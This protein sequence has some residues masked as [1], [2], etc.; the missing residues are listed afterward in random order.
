MTPEQLAQERKELISAMDAICDTY[1]G[2][3]HPLDA[4][5]T[6]RRELAVYSYRLSAH[7]KQ[8][9]GEAGLAYAVRK[10]TIAKEILRERS[11]DAKKPEPMNVLEV[12]VLGVDAVKLAQTDEV[13]KDA[14]REAL[15]SKLD[16][17]KQVLSSLNQEISVEANE[18]RNAHY[19]N[20]GA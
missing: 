6:M 18:R 19:Q 3:G 15:K 7:V 17:V 16:F 5:I 2:G 10:H 11:V 4:L 14:A 9:F 20:A 1:F 12:K 8:V 13:W